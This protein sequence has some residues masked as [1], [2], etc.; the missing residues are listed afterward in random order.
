MAFPATE[1]TGVSTR[2]NPS[3][4]WTYRMEV[5]PTGAPAAAAI[6]TINDPITLLNLLVNLQSQML[7]LQRQS[8][9][10][11]R[12]QLELARENTQVAREQRAR[13]ASE[14]ER[15]QAGHERVIDDCKEALGKLEQVHAS[16]MGELAEYVDEHHENLLDGDFALSDFVDR[17][18]PRLAHLN[19]ML[20][21]LR[22]LAAVMK[23]AD[24]P[25][26]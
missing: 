21:V 6:P 10:L 22:P 16:L 19:T 8:L 18:G 3:P 11:Q 13:Q 24:T 14:L 17:F 26:S 12:Q 1:E 4:P 9:D 20:A 5:S 2:E 25:T 15:W 7:E 23:K